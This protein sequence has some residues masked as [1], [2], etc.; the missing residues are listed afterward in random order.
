MVDSLARTLIT[1]GGLVVLAAMCGIMVFLVVSAAPLFG[2]ATMRG[3]GPAGVAEQ[4]AA[5]DAVRVINGADHALLIADGTLIDLALGS[6]HVGARLALAPEDEISAMTF[7]PGRWRVT[8]GTADGRILT[9]TVGSV[10]HG[11]SD[12]AA[13]VLPPL[14]P[15]TLFRLDDDDLRNRLVEIMNL[16]EPIDSSA[17]I[18]HTNDGRTLLWQPRVTDATELQLRHGDGAITCID[19]NGF[20]DRQRFVAATRADGTA[21]FAVIRSVVRLDGGGTVDRAREYEFQLDREGQTPLRL[22][23]PSDGS[24]VIAVW[25]DGAFSRFDTRNPREIVLAE[26]GRVVPDGSEL[27]AATMAIGGQTLLA[28]DSQGGV[29]AWLMADVAAPDAPDGRKLV[30]KWKHEYGSSPVV[31]LAPGDRDRTALIA[32]ENGELALVHLTSEKRFASVKFAAVPVAVC[33]SPSNDLIFSM[34]ASGSYQTWRLDPGFPSVSWRSLFGKIQYE[35]YPEPAWVYQSTGDASSEPKYSIVP[36]A[37]GTL[38]ATFFAMLFATPLAVLAAMYASEFMHRSV[39]RVVKP[40][41]ELMASLPS[42]VIGFVAAMVVAPFVRAWLPSLMV[43]M[44]VIP[45][46]AVSGGML[47]QL[48][49]P[50]YARRLGSRIQLAMLFLV[51]AIALAASAALGP[52][53]ERTLFRPSIDDALVRAGSFE[54]IPDAEVPVLARTP[55]RLSSAQRAAL[56]AQ[57]VYIVDGRAV[58]PTSSEVEPPRDPSIEQWLDGGFG[59]AWPGWLIALMPL[60]ALLIPLV[61][62]KLFGRRWTHL[63]DSLSGSIAGWLEMFRLVTMIVT[64]VAVAAAG[65]WTLQTLGFDPRDSIFGRFTQKNTLVVGIVMGFAVIPIIFTISEDALS[66]VPRSLRSASLGAG[67]TPWQ[68]AFRV[69]LPVAGSGIFSACMIGLGRAVGETMIVLMATGNTPEM[70]LNIFSGFRTLSASIAVELPEAPRGGTHYRVL[71]LCGLTL[72]VMTLLINTTAEVVRQ[73]FRRRNAA[74]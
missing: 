11:V 43:G 23:V 41:I 51:F 50:R 58:R 19:S 12:A 65:A 71:F 49:P 44:L 8:L 46:I 55:E 73:R 39:H 10:W 2:G 17:Y 3:S 54:P 34:D 40:T 42:V 56:R 31:A 59:S 74:L 68:T 70:N 63:L 61:H 36:L 32:L 16:N 35:G 60:V 30:R 69:V 45:L 64:I 52:T 13:S 22:F 14:Q 33:A 38:K 48:I 20:G 4:F 5:P 24:C 28:G 66:S 62:A 53:V 21:I 67:A 9:R 37:W 1:S 57:G 47:W 15:G 18:E 26:S 72:F 7:E 27:T 29:S 25:S 6:G